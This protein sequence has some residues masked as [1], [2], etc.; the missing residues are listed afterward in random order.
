MDTDNDL[1]QRHLT[2]L[3]AH[4]LRLLEQDNKV[5]DDNRTVTAT[6]KVGGIVA[7][8]LPSRNDKCPCGSGRKYKQCCQNVPRIF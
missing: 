4:Q 6:G 5:V 7:K 8:K 2:L 1:V 3:L